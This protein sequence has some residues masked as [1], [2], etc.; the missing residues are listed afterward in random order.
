[1]A[2]LAQEIILKSPRKGEQQER[3]LSGKYL[4]MFRKLVRKV[5][6]KRFW[7]G[8]FDANL[9]LDQIRSTQ[10]IFRRI[11]QKE[12]LFQKEKRIL[13][14]PFLERDEVQRKIAELIIVRLNCMEMFN[15]VSCFPYQIDPKLYL[16]IQSTRI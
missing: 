11:G 3:V 5:I 7:Q 9:S 10:N 8:I 15:P 2:D 16:R 4:F 12:L 13:G 14:I 1:M 6:L